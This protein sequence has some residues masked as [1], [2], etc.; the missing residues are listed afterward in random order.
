MT[1][2]KRPFRDSIFSQITPVPM[3]EGFTLD[4]VLDMVRRV[5][6]ARRVES[7]TRD[8]SVV[9]LV[10]SEDIHGMVCREMSKRALSSPDSDVVLNIPI[11]C[12]PNP[13]LIYSRFSSVELPC[14]VA[15]FRPRDVWQFPDGCLLGLDWSDMDVWLATGHVDLGNPARHFLINGIP[16]E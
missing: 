10:A 11:K 2:P 5:L 12:A 16:P 14:V 15:L 4:V 6:I 9:D 13:T 7:P 3:S 8:H 1:E